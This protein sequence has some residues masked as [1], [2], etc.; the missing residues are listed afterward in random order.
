MDAAAKPPG[1][2]A[3]CLRSTASQASERTAA[4]G[5]AGLGGLRPGDIIQRVNELP[6][7]TLAEFRAHIR[8]IRRG[9]PREVVF[10]VLRG[11]ETTFIRVEPQWK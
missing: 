2:R 9:K 5:W 8:T 3:L 1:V 11:A 10:F 4:S 7:R 6:V